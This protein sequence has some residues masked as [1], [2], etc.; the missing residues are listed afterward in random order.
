MGLSRGTKDLLLLPEMLREPPKRRERY[1]NT[2]N[3]FLLCPV[4]S[5]HCLQLANLTGRQVTR[6]SR[7]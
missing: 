2:L 4:I 1:R 3:Y 7:K 5:H 6:E